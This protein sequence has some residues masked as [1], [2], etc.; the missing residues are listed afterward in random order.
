VV[1]RMKGKSVAIWIA[2]SV[3]MK[4]E[5]SEWC[6]W[7][8]TRRQ[9]F[10]VWCFTIYKYLRAHNEIWWDTSSLVRRIRSSQWCRRMSTGW[11]MCICYAI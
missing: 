4:N 6:K 11:C 5:K 2:F 3:R 9:S 10:V 8:M 7:K 1:K